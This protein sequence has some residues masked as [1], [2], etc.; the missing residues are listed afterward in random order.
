VAPVEGTAVQGVLSSVSD[1]GIVLAV[2][3]GKGRKKETVMKE[4]PLSGI[5]TVRV[6]IVF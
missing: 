2:E 6:M 4:I 1:E 3:S 5:K